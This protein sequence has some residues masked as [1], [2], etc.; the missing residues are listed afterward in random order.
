MLKNPSLPAATGHVTKGADIPFM[1]PLRPKTSGP[2]LFTSLC[3]AVTLLRGAVPGFAAASDSPA[4][5][6]FRSDAGVALSPGALP[7]NLETPEALRWRVPLD[8]GHSTP[9]VQSGRIFLTSY[10]TDS[11][12]L[13]TV[14][15]DEATGKI[16]WRKA[17]VPEKVEQTHEIGSPAT[18]TIACDGKRLFAFFGSAGL[19]CYDLDGKKL[20]E[21]RLGPF[22]DEYGAGSSPIVFDNKVIL[23]Q[24]HD[25]D[26]FVL[27]LDAADGHQVWKTARPDAVR[28]YST[29]MIWNHDGHPQLLVAGALQLSAYDPAS[30]ERLWWQNGLARI[31]IPT[32]VASGP[33][34]YMASWAPGGDTGKRVTFLPW[35]D[36]LA[37]WDANHDGKLSKT[38][39]DDHEVLERFFRMD[40]D[41]DGALNRDE[42]ERHAAFFT[43][44]ENSVLAIKPTG[45]GELPPS[46]LSWKH[47]RGIPYVPT[48]VLDH[49]ILWMVKDGGIVTKLDAAT[50]RLLQEERVP[51]VGRYFASP[52]AGDGKV[53]FASESGSVSVVAAEPEWR[54]ISTREF[55]EKIFATPVL[56]RGRLYLRT[57]SALYSFQGTA[58]P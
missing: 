35:P 23:S 56:E 19:F 5:K 48:P 52:A 36:A 1:S 11:R 40:L 42:W 12:E 8:G 30:G 6:Y 17:L 50:G 53:Y 10:R 39:I 27:A 54:V 7:A 20:W 55:H 34:I 49:N 16:L 21:K 28:S 43:R 9:I 18:A 38:E 29:P 45:R 47:T 32:P 37:K 22:R 46:A 58:K 41:Q 2:R 15:L 44:A 25:I 57:E 13:A 26:S 51:G 4:A 33:T 31:V 24:D 14:A 3:C